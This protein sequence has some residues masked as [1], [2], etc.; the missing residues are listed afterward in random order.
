MNTTFIRRVTGGGLAALMLLS[1]GQALAE[2]IDIKVTVTIV[3]PP[4][5]VINGDSLIEVDFGNEVMTT[6]ID[7]SYKKQAINYTVECKDAPSN[8]MK[9]QIQGNGAGF[10]GDVLQTNKGNL[11]IALL[12]SG[13]S[14]PINEWINFTYPNLPRLEAV[15]VKKAGATLTGGAF[16][17]GATMKVEYQ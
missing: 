6:R 16:S 17:A 12:R 7:G 2:N 11:G 5:C 13:S 14:Q 15:P 3:A 4:P 1:G 9:L 10:D 8:A